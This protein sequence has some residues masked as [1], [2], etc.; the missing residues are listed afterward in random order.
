[1][2]I[3]FPH[4]PGKGGPGS[5]QK[6][7]ENSLK[8]KGWDIEYRSS[9]NRPDVIFVVGGTKQIFWLLKMKLKKVPIIFR[10]DGINWLHWKKKVGIKNF[11]LAE[12]RNFSCKIIHA[13]IADKIIYQ[14]DFVEHWWNISGWRKRKNTSVIYNGISILNECKD[15][16]DSPNKVELIVLEGNIDYS[17]YAVKLLNDLAEILKN[18][19]KITLYGNFE[20]IEN[21]KKLSPLIAYNGFLKFEKVNDV[22]KN[23]IYLSLDINPACPN[24]VIEALSSGAP[25]VGFDTGSLKELVVSDSGIIV[26]YGSNPWNLEY[27]DVKSLAKAILKIKGNYGHYSQNARKIAEKRYSI[28]DMTEK[29]ISVI[30]ALLRKS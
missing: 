10:L 1:M 22:M 11:L 25:V 24:T 14:S 13:F 18:D 12:Y 16:N 29:Y 21:Q 30:K 6:R 15:L 19:I 7:F 4:K 27:P 3:C 8:S 9:E 20:F 23:K 28:E 2:K 5:F 17:P 26:Q